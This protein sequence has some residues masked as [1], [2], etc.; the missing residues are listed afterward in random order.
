MHHQPD[1]FLMCSGPPKWKDLISC[2]LVTHECIPLITAI[3]L[4]KN[5]IRVVRSL[6]GDDAQTF[7]DKIDEVPL[8]T[9][10]SWKNSL[11]IQTLNSVDQALDL[12]NLMPW[13]RT[14]CLRTLCRIC[15]CQALLP[16]SL[17]IPLCYDRLDV[18]RYR[19]GYADVWM[20]KHQG[21]QVAVKVLRVYS[22]S[23]F[24]KLINVGCLCVI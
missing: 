12:P 17:Q 20:G 21:L 15:G 6:K 22:T 3:F 24:D 10:S 2:P 5:E 19:G 23:D 8:N 7:I 13:L 11:L 4:D 16:K 18:P 14:K 1:Q 9:L